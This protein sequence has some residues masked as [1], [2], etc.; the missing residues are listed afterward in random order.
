[1][2][3]NFAPAGGD[4]E[5]H[6]PQH[7]AVPSVLS[8]QARLPEPTLMFRELLTGWRGEIIWV[9]STAAIRLSA[10]RSER[11]YLS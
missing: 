1:M 9:P 6:C 7:T 4:T 3:M 2:S 8:P 11:V 5:A 10:A